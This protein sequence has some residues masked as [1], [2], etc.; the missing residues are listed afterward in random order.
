LAWDQA[1]VVLFL[2]TVATLLP[3]TL[4]NWGLS[5]GTLGLLY[6]YGG[7]GGETG[8]MVSL[9]FRLMAVPA[10]LLGWTF[11]LFR[12]PAP[13]D[14][15]AE[16]STGN[17]NQEVFGAAGTVRRYASLQDLFPAEK[18]L[19]DRLAPDLPRAHLLDLGVGGG[20]TT[21]HLA[22][23][24][25]RYLGADYAPAMVEACRARF[26]ALPPEA[27]AV[28][29]ARALPAAWTSAFD[30][31]LFSYNGL[32]FLDHGERL[33]S[34]REIARVLKPGGWFAFSSHNLAAVSRDLERGLSGGWDR[35]LDV[36]AFRLLN[37]DA[38][39]IA[40]GP[41]GI[42]RDRGNKAR[43]RNY[44]IRPEAQEEQLREAGFDPVATWPASGSGRGRKGPHGHSLGLQA[45]GDAAQA[46]DDRWIH[47]LA[48]RRA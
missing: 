20:R 47:Y 18:A 46:S 13:A 44:Y 17:R 27:F 43:A 42:L 40:K 7:A 12:R 15:A 14:P 41:Y 4:G 35:A 24:V 22:S 38:A 21:A 8:V 10:A 36:A 39:A 16:P 11:F 2:F 26:P 32:D 5:E 6:K 48:R 28:A 30:V 31:V 45:F 19:L 29:D 34:L 33:A 23:R 1:L 25:A 3:I 37:K 9:L